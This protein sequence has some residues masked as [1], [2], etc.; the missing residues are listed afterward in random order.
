MNKFKL[1]MKKLNSLCKSTTILDFQAVI[2]V[3]S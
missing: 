3:L 2:L 1:W